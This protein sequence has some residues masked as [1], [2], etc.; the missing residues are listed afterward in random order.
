[1]A[2]RISFLKPSGLILLGLLLGF[3]AADGSP[4]TTPLLAGQCLSLQPWFTALEDSTGTRSAA[5]LAGNPAAFVPLA[6]MPK[7]DPTS[8][9]WLRA[10]FRT[11]DLDDPGDILTFNHL[12]FVDIY[13]YQDNNLIIHK[14]SGA[15]LPRSD[16][17]DGD[18]RLYTVLPLGKNSTYTLLIRVHHTKHYQPVFDFQLLPKR[19]YFN[20]LHAKESIDAALMGAIG[21][22]F[23]YTLLSWLASRFRPYLWLL[24]FIGG[25]G[26][27]VISLNGYWIDWF[28]PESPAAAWM[29]N[30]HFL[31]LGMLG[32]YLLVTDFWRL[33][34]DY[35][36]LYSWLRWVPPGIVISSVACFCIDY[37]TGN[38][39]LASQISGFEH[40]LMLGFIVATLWTCW[41]RLNSARR[42]LAYGIL[43]CGASGLF[44][45]V[46]ALVIHEQAF[47]SIGLVGDCLVLF[48]FLLFSTGL[49][50]EMRQHELTKQAALEE[51]TRLQQ[52][53]NNLLEKRVE[54]RTAELR[55]SNKRLLNQK[56]LLAERNS[57]IETLINELNHRVKNNLQL[58]YSLLSLQLPM[59]RDGT[60]RDILKGNIGK[61]RAMMLVNQKLFNSE[62]GRSIGLCEFISELAVHLQKIYDTKEKTRI[63]QDIP[64][65]L[66]LSDK[67]TLSFGLIL[68]ELFTNTFKHAFR[69][70]PD[71]CIRVEAVALNDH[72]LEFVYSDNG[73]GIPAGDNADDNKEKFTMGIPLIKD[74]TRQM[75]GQM[76]ISGDKGL[77]YSFTIPV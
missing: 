74:L 13:L 18:G 61:I 3:G 36:R 76:T 46:R 17:S 72:L 71:P 65:S 22:F 9:Y 52:Q 45:A 27:Y 55:V 24:V 68:S 41:P 37:F 29:L 25:I 34:K 19:Q 20:T 7:G 59:V 16:L 2:H 70:H 47:T 10:T 64:A 32:L 1:M 56:H 40:P 75:N 38:F 15:F 57:K 5:G 50:E 23:V 48:I 66:R 49:K 73:I 60:S 11:N 53:Q 8:Y 54:E 63:M 21:L 31:H 39:S 42:Y 43:L 28:S 62:K 33:K 44:V 26:C 30:V 58:L 4:L 69:D 6:S 12:T 67:H 14:R 51:L 35:P 77:S